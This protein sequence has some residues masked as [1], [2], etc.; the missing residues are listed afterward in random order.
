M[1]SIVILHLVLAVCYSRDTPKSPT[2]LTFNS[3]KNLTF[4]EKSHMLHRENGL[5]HIVIAVWRDAKRLR[6]SGVSAE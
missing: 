1:V 4:I 6:F 2:N 5:Y 3:N